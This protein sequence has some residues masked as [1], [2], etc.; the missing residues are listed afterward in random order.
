M[1]YGWVDHTAELEPHIKAPAETAVFA[2]VLR[3][4]A[5]LVSEGRRMEDVLF[6]VT[7]D[8]PDRATLLA[9]WLDELV[10]RAET[11]GVVPDAVERLVLAPQ[12]LMARVRAHRS[13]ATALEPHGLHQRRR[14]VLGHPGR[15]PSR[16][17]RPRP[18]LRRRDAP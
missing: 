1:A 11:A 13:E 3:A 6:D 18:R 15:H 5:E 2:G 8:A 17:A 9:A 7:L 4:F 16:H 12:G 10:Y 14:G